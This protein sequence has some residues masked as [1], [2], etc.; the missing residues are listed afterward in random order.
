MKLALAFTTAVLLAIPALPVGAQ[1]TDDCNAARCAAQTQFD[2]CMANATNHGQ[3]VSCVAHAV[4]DLAKADP[5]TFK[6]CKGKIVRCAARST[7]GK[8]GKFSTC[9]P[10]CVIPAGASSGTCADDPSMVCTSNFDCG[11]C[12][13]RLTGTCPA[14]TTEGTGSCCPP[15]TCST[16]TTT[17]P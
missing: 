15:P 5:T 11:R 2:H 3:C 8:E 4:K 1:N 14:G 9:T 6:S 12:H 17:M 7:C 16:T 13:T 10:T